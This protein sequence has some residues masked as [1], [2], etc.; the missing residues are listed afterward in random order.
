MAAN[1]HLIWVNF[2]VPLSS[3]RFNIG[4]GDLVL[5]AAMSVHLRSRSAGRVVAAAPGVIGLALALLLASVPGSQL[6]PI[7]APLS[8]SL[9]PFL[10]AGWLCALAA[11]RIA[12]TTPRPRSARRRPPGAGHR[13][14]ES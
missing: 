3:G 4:F 10:T 8:M 6:V 5:V 12:A 7:V 11:S 1:P 13:G 14:P 2:R 9:I